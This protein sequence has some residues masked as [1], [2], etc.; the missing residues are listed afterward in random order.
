[1]MN[2]EVM[3]KYFDDLGTLVEGLNL[4]GKAHLIGTATRWEKTLNTIR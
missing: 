2:R 1:M 4:E 3:N